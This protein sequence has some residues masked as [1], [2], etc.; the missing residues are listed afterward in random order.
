[1]VAHFPQAY[2]SKEFRVPYNA[3]QKKEII[4]HLKEWF[5]THTDGAI[6][7]IDGV[8]VTFDYGWGIVRP[9]NTQP[10]LS[11]RFEANSMQD[12]YRVRDH[13][14]AALSTYLDKQS[15]ESQLQIE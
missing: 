10:V 8:H 9:S 5:A 13:F 14:I 2:S 15:L 1:M 7:T 3:D 11:M 6:L 4:E 12:L